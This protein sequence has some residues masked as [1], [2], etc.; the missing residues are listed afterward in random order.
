MRDKIYFV[1]DVHLGVPTLEASHARE[2]HLIKWLNKVEQDA[3]E[4]IILGDL[5]DF[6]FEYKTVVPKGFVRLFGKLADLS[7]KGITISIF[8]GNHDIWMFDYF[9][10]EFGIQ[11]YYKEQIR[12]INGK[13]LFIAHGDGYGPGDHGFKFIKKIFHNKV[14]QSLFQL[15]HPDFTMGFALWWSRKSRA[16]GGELKYEGDDKEYLYQFVKHYPKEEKIDYFVFGHRHLAL[17]KKIGDST[18][19]NLGDWITLYTYAVFDGEKV[20]LK[21]FEKPV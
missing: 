1:S 2:K 8:I 15:V 6:W 17:D 3:K 5:F 14:C 10:K 11:V 7:D 4:I 21:E 20:E 16:A 18:Y 19:I 13:K 9:Q 12:E